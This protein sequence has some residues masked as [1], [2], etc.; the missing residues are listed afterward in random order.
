MFFDLNKL[1]TKI[2]LLSI[3]LFGSLSNM[4][5]VTVLGKLKFLHAFYDFKKANYIVEKANTGFGEHLLKLQTLAKNQKSSSLNDAK[6]I[7]DI[8]NFSKGSVVWL[9]GTTPV[10]KDYN[11]PGARVVTFENDQLSALKVFTYMPEFLEEDLLLGETGE[12]IPLNLADPDVLNT[13]EDLRIFEGEGKSPHCLSSFLKQ[14]ACTDMGHVALDLL[15]TTPTTSVD[16]LKTRQ[17]IIQELAAK[18]ALLEK[19]DL[20]LTDI[21]NYESDFFHFCNSRKYIEND[22]EDSVM[23]KKYMAYYRSDLGLAFIDDQVKSMYNM[24]NRSDKILAFNA[25]FFYQKIMGQVLHVKNAMEVFWSIK[26]GHGLG[27]NQIGQKIWERDPVG[28][29]KE[30]G[31]VVRT[32]SY[33]PTFDAISDAKKMILDKDAWA[34]LNP[35]T[36]RNPVDLFKNFFNTACV[37]QQP[38]F[39]TNGFMRFL[40]EGKTVLEA[41]AFFKSS[42]KQWRETFP[43]AFIASYNRLIGVSKYLKALNRLSKLME[44]LPE[45]TEKLLLFEQ[46]KNFEKLKKTAPANAVTPFQKYLDQKLSERMEDV[47]NDEECKKWTIQS[48]LEQPVPLKRLQKLEDRIELQSAS[49]VLKLLNNLESDTFSKDVARDFKWTSWRRGKILATYKMMFDLKKHFYPALWAIGEID[50]YCAV[51]KLVNKYKNDALNKVTFVQFE[52]DSVKPHLNIDKVWNPLTIPQSGDRSKKFVIVPN[53]VELGKSDENCHMMI[54]GDN[55]IGKSTFMRSVC[56][57][58]WMGQV[59]GIAPATQI[60]FTPFGYIFSLKKDLEN[61]STGY[62]T[63]EAQL[64][65]IKAVTTSLRKMSDRGIYSLASFDEI[66]NG[67]NF[68]IASSNT[69]GISVD[70]CKN[71]KN[72]MWILSSHAKG[73]DLIE[74]KTGKKICNYKI[75]GQRTLERGINPIKNTT[76]LELMRKVGFSA[77]VVSNAE[78]IEQELAFSFVK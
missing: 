60:S 56:Y 35:L 48:L 6:K 65:K 1:A 29:A 73:V 59:F 61:A 23:C 2:V 9:G 47:K 5:A 37:L 17:E 13:I 63:H 39:A 16:L 15:L 66:F 57:A 52:E 49:N 21:K 38:L 53:S 54:T 28:S 18:P 30:V 44:K 58:V 26:N 33:G 34:K 55:T 4:Q 31:R 50:A 41:P 68:Q 46:L 20:C 74:Q 10:V 78:Q 24:M 8:K 72:T 27:L 7:K 14:Q 45:V 69:I 71:I 42:Y 51:A 75:S 62:S 40:F 3:F 32:F 22:A 11:N 19:I 64:R 77:D 12:K 70:M 25:F 43:A 36:N 76:N 67:T